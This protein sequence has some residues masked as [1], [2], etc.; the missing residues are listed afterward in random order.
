MERSYPRLFHN[1]AIYAQVFYNI[2]LCTEYNCWENVPEFGRTCAECTARIRRQQAAQPPGALPK[3]SSPQLQLAASTRAHSRRRSRSPI[4]VV[5]C[6]VES[7]SSGGSARS[8]IRSLSPRS[9]E[10]MVKE[11]CASR[12]DVQA[13][14]RVMAVLAKSIA[15]ALH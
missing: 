1:Y 11:W 10:A 4:G 5:Q 13:K 3:S 15:D 14:S 12:G 6:K 9:H 7:N 8:H 2:L